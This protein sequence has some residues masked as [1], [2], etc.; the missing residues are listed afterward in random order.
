MPMSNAQTHHSARGIWRV[1]GVPWAVAEPLPSTGRFASSRRSSADIPGQV[2]SEPWQDWMLGFLLVFFGLLVVANIFIPSPQ[3]AWVRSLARLPLR[4]AEYAGL[5][6][7]SLG[8]AG[9]IYL[10]LR[11]RLPNL[12]RGMGFGMLMAVIVQAALLVYWASLSAWE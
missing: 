8:A 12:S 9:G 6:A 5:I 11:Q 1:G 4:A 10:A 2:T 7:G 3:G